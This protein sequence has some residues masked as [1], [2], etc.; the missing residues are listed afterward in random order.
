MLPAT[1]ATEAYFFPQELSSTH[2]IGRSNLIPV[3]KSEPPWLPYPQQNDTRGICPLISLP[4]PPI[5]NFLNQPL[6]FPETPWTYYSLAPRH[7][8]FLSTFDYTGTG[9]DFN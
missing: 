3:E 9:S 5:F 6:G 8:V 7:K 2:R 4:P 1:E